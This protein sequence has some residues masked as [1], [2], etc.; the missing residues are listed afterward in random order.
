[1]GPSL[2]IDPYSTV[3][4]SP[5]KSPTKGIPSDTNADVMGPPSRVPLNTIEGASNILPFSSLHGSMDSN[6]KPSSTIPPARAPYALPSK[7]KSGAAAKP[8][9][10]DLLDDFKAAVVGSDLTKAGLIEVLKKK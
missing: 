10:S 4:W 2:P 7:S 1:M 6:A 3:Y 9:P 5:Q 8:L